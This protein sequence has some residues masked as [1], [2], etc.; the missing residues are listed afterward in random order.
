MMLPLLLPVISQIQQRY[1]QWEMLEQLE[2]KELVTIE[3]NQSEIQWIKNGKE[4]LVHG[5]LFDVKQYDHKNGNYIL[6]GLFD[7]KEKALH[8]QLVQQTEKQQKPEQQS[9][10]IKLLTSNLM[11]P[12]SH[13]PTPPFCLFAKEY[14]AYR[15]PL[16]TNPTSLIISPP[17]EQI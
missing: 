11:L 7:S 13:E 15:N 10:L 8:Q 5:E 1:I 6:T 17:P 4:C 3:V 14:S 9:R 2:Q 16:Y 12:A